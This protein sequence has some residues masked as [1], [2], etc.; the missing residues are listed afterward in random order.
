MFDRDDM[1][2]NDEPDP[3]A[4]NWTP[5]LIGLGLLIVAVVVA[6]VAMGWW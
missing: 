2:L 5:R 1:K 6:G 4:P 3:A